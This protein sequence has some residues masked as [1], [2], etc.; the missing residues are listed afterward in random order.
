ML[1]SPRETLQYRDNVTFSAVLSN[2]NVISLHQLHFSPEPAS[3]R[4]MNTSK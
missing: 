2:V 4:Q 1:F 3:Y